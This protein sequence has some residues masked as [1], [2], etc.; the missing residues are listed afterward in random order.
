MEFLV[1]H[2]VSLWDALDGDVWHVWTSELSTI[3][4]VFLCSLPQQSVSVDLQAP[5]IIT[6]IYYTCWTAFADALP[7]WSLRV[8]DLPSLKRSNAC[9]LKHKVI[10]DL[11][12]S[13]FCQAVV[14]STFLFYD[15][16][17]RY[18]TARVLVIDWCSRYLEYFES[19][20]CWWSCSFLCHRYF[21]LTV[22]MEDAWASN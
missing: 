15:G 20:R 13:V 5:R 3:E 10:V 21:F 7:P 19:C 8:Q 14:G 22:E 2:R 1:S 12:M 4:Q 18:L 9:E 11:A 16:F 17:M 6:A